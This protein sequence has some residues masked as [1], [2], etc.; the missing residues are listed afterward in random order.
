[1][2]PKQKEII[3]C[4]RQRGRLKSSQLAVLLRRPC[5]GSLRRD[6]KVL[7][8]RGVIENRYFSDRQPGYLLKGA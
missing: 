8:D 4:L 5:D 1:M 6:L 3:A 7:S 2:S